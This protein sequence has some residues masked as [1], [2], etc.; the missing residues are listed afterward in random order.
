MIE[1]NISPDWRSLED[2]FMTCVHE[3]AHL[4]A[5]RHYGGDGVIHVYPK[6][7]DKDTE[8]NENGY[9][10][11]GKMQVTL[12]PYGDPQRSSIMLGLSGMC[13][14]LLFKN[15]NP[16]WLWQDLMHSW[17]NERDTWSNS[18][19]ALATCDGNYYLELED[20]EECAELINQ[21]AETIRLLAVEAYEKIVGQ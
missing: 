18:D 6:K 9:Y 13:G 12:S 15:D 16:A 11:V 4:M 19:I 14:E 20:F 1:E 21:E 3:A 5:I 2:I 17:E 8:M 10:S 7:P